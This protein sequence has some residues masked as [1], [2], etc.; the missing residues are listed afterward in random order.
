MVREAGAIGTFDKFNLLMSVTSMS[1]PLSNLYSMI[2]KVHPRGPSNASFASS[3][4][5]LLH[6]R[7]RKCVSVETLHMCTLI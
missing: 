5:M 2:T 3:A 1:S 7:H 4:S 6:A